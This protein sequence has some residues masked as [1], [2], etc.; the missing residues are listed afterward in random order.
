MGEAVHRN[1]VRGSTT[2]PGVMMHS[3]SHVIVQRRQPTRGLRRMLPNLVKPATSGQARPNSTTHTFSEHESGY[4][5]LSI[6]GASVSRTLRGQR[7]LATR[8]RRDTCVSC[9]S[10][11]ESTA[12]L[13]S[14]RRRNTLLLPPPFTDGRCRRL[15]RE[16]WRESLP[17]TRRDRVRRTDFGFHGVTT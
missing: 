12:L 2:A 1:G 14:R 9:R 16:S 8:Y 7:V 13:L 11:L 10:M 3:H 4:G 15:S 6:R 17:P 5:L